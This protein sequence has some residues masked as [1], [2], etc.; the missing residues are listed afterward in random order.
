MY[1]GKSILDIASNKGN[2]ILGKIDICN[3]IQKYEKINVPIF[4]DDVENLDSNNQQKIASMID[5][6]L[7]MLAVNDNKDLEVLEG[8]IRK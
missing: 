7:I 3:S 8:V 5:C 2:R 4:L 6:Q 1:D